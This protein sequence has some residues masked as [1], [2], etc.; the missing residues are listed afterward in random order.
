MHVRQQALVHITKKLSKLAL[1]ELGH[2]LL[3][4]IHEDHGQWELRNA[5]H[6]PALH[7]YS[8]LTRKIQE[9]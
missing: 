5:L 7:S 2:G 6:C 9:G 8:R 3:L 4:R 1:R